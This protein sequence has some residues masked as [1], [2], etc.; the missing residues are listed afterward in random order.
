MLTILILPHTLTPRHTQYYRQFCVHPWV[1]K[2]AKP[3]FEN[4][5]LIMVL[6][7]NE[8]V[9]ILP[10]TWACATIC[11]SMLIAESKLLGENFGNR[12]IHL[13][14]LPERKDKI[15]KIFMLGIALAINTEQKKQ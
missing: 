10:S 14:S 15:I 6:T 3:Q 4:I 1:K 2:W 13:C 11:S 5:K 12:K 9:R 7:N 8:L